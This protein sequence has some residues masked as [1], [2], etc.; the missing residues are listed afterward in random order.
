MPGAH[1]FEP[2]IFH[3]RQIRTDRPVTCASTHGQVEPNGNSAPN[4][5]QILASIKAKT[6][7]PR[8]ILVT[9]TRGTGCAT[10]PTDAHTPLLS[11]E[12]Y[13]KVLLPAIIADQT[14]TACDDHPSRAAFTHR[15]PQSV[16][17]THAMRTRGHANLA[18]TWQAQR[19]IVTRLVLRRVWPR[20]SHASSIGW[21]RPPRRPANFTTCAP[22]WCWVDRHGWV[23]GIIPAECPRFTTIGH[24][25]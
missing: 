15:S 8:F 12:L 13:A 1:R 22:S 4:C 17:L 14:T 6:V 16:R 23:I 20:D 2:F 21:T 9:T 18:I 7:R 25:L 10:R 24:T 3:H 5:D 11:A 19:Q